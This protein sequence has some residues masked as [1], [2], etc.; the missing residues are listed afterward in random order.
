MLGQHEYICEAKIEQ[1]DINKS[2]LGRLKEYVKQHR[3][4]KYK[5][6]FSEK[7]DKLNNFAAYGKKTL[8]SGDYSCSQE[9]F[10]KYILKALPEMEADEAFA[11]IY[12]KL[13]NGD[14]LPKLKSSDNSVIPYQLHLKELVKIL[15]NASK[16]LDFLEQKDDDG[17][18]VKEK[19][20][21]IFK[22]KISLSV[23]S[24]E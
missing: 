12:Q 19:I 2:D 3:P 9:D 13:K 22:F 7:R 17:I 18:T 1:Y 5:E 10:C 16:Y 4:E 11:D 14:F 6:I 20:I 24:N 21:S 8:S 23:L 15:D